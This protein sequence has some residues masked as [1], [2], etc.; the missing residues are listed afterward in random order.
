[1]TQ[2]VSFHAAGMPK[3]Q[4]SKRGF[5]VGG[6]V[7]LVESGGAAHKD[8]RATV[9]AE[10]TA[11]MRHRTPEDGPLRLEV[12]FY[13]PR[14]KSHPKTRRTWPIA[15]PDIDKLVRSI[16]DSLTHVVWRDDSQVVELRARKTWAYDAVDHE[17]PAGALV[18]VTR[19]AP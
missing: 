13:L 19:L 4:G 12:T 6:K 9:T 18:T 3:P 11:A 16:A 17:R 7:R 14:P 1:M 2:V 8:W 15:R 5:A 10:A